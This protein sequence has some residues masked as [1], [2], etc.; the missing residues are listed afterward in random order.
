MRYFI[1]IEKF[2]FRQI[3]F[4]EQKFIANLLEKYLKKS[5]WGSDDIV[6]IASIQL[7]LW[8]NLWHPRSDRMLSS[9]ISV[10]ISIDDFH[11]AIL[12]FVQSYDGTEMEKYSLH[13]E[14][15]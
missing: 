8:N 14:W 1:S 7:E 12:L 5:D 13:S 3:F 9:K 10:M 15:K 11:L 2:K 6:I 4:M